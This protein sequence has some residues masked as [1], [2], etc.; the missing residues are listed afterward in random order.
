MERI[1]L[2][3]PGIFEFQH[4]DVNNVLKPD[5]ALLKV[6][7]IG[8]CGTD[9][10]AYAGEQPFFDYP[11]ILGHEL[12]VEVVDIGEDVTNV[13]IGDKCSVEPYRATHSNDWAIKRGKPNC[14]E[15]LSVLGV[16]E[17]G[18]MREYFTIPAKY[19]H[20]SK[21]LSY[22]QLALIEPLSIGCHAVNRAEITREDT[23]VVVGS[24]PIGLGAI[25]FARATGARVAVMEI[26][27]QRLNFCKRQLGIERFINPT[28][29]ETETQIRSCFNG[30]LPTI[31]LDATG[32]KQSMQRT[33][34]YAAHGGKVVFIGL[35]QGDV[36]FHDPD[37][38]K[39]ELTLMSSRNSLSSDFKQIICSIEEGEIDTSP[40]ITHRAHFEKM[41]S[42]FDEWVKP[43]S[44]VIKAMVE[45]DA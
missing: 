8:I 17:D 12:G 24:G 29:G 7:N 15:H 45:L 41:I 25:Q 43:E 36:T 39:K 30:A 2:Q 38:H 44:N 42:Q 23:V 40:W 14:A 27:K 10:H 19:L 28:E 11:R 16:H 31:V 5:E 33:F 21:E 18:G 34:S 35:F 6:H 3:E 9:L 4:V 26:S 1:I 13:Q 32:S 22:D 37:F 20:S